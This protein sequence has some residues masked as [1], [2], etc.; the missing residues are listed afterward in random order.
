MPIHVGTDLEPDTPELDVEAEKPGRAILRVEFTPE[1]LAL[2]RRAI[3]RGPGMVRFVKSAALEVAG[4][5]AKTKSSDSL[6]AAD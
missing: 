6:H 1:E 4:R 3:G 5:K 2:L